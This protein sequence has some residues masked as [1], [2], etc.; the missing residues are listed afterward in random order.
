MRTHE[1]DGIDDEAR[2]GHLDNAVVTDLLA[3]KQDNT[4]S[5]ERKIEHQVSML[6]MLVR[7]KAV[8]G[9]IRIRS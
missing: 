9:R 3:G 7:M 8:C 5:P 1:I 6:R 4:G 2:L